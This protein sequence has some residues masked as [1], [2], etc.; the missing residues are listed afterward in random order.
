MV[1]WPEVMVTYDIGEKILFSADAFGTF[2]ALDGA[3][4]ADEVDFFGDYLMKRAGIIL[5]LLVTRQTGAGC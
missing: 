5:I 3:L 1:H 2:G 4:F